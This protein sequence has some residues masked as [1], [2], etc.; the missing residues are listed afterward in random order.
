MR[1]FLLLSTVV[2][3]GACSEAGVGVATSSSF[4]DATQAN[5]LAQQIAYQRG[6]YLV[7]ANVRFSQATQDTVMFAFGRADLSKAT[8]KALDGQAKWLRENPDIRMSVTGHTDLVG[9]E[10]FNDKLGMRRAQAVTQYL[11]ARGVQQG[12]VEAVESRGESEPA[13]N[14]AGPEAKNRRAITSVAGF[15]HG[16]IGDPGDGARARLMYQRYATDAV[17]EPARANVVSDGG[18]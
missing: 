4:G 13:V 7:D 5:E 15:T 17:E 2:V 9:G 11:L 10:R 1:A 12:R 18:S 14:A 3:L 16:F 8:R 6:Q